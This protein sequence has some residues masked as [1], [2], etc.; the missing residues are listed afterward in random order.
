MR[1]RAGELT[2]LR[3]IA[4]GG[5]GSASRGEPWGVLAIF[6]AWTRATGTALGRVTQPVEWDGRCLVV[7]VADPVWLR[8]LE[9]MA[10]QIR[11][12][13]N[14]HLAVSPEPGAGPPRVAEIRFRRA[15]PGA[16]G[17]SSA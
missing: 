4:A 5:S 6:D 1:R 10:S 8:N 17:G 7:E 13:L 11:E 12:A 15:V 9:G 16:D 3:A 14:Q 2:S